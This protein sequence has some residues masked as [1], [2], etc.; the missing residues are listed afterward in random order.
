MK[1]FIRIVSIIGLIS[2]SQLAYPDSIT[3]TY[4]TGDTLTATTLNN[5]KSAVNDN[6]SRITALEATLAAHIANLSN[7]HAVTKDQVGLANLEDIRVNYTAITSPTVDDDVNSGYSVGSV[8]I[9]V[10]KKQ[11]YVLVDSSAGQAVWKRV[12]NT[13]DI[14]QEGPAGGVVFF[15]TG[16]GLHGLEAAPVDQSNAAEW[17][18]VIGVDIP[19]ADGTAI[20]TGAQNT[21][22]ILAA[23]P[24]PGIAARLADNYQLNG[25]TDWYLPS[26]D[27][28]NVMRLNIGLINTTT[29]NPG[30]FINDFYWSS[31]EQAGDGAWRQF[32]STGGQGVSGKLQSYSVR[33]IRAF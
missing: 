20:G 18:C 17:G 4:N 2:V 33:A 24:N 13:Y 16:G 6:D 23:C 25:F 5:I 30:N 9:D 11:A 26:K 32:F 15:V 28:L 8:W 21:A 1:Y 19:G 14:G 3:D 29:G 27:T 31:S 22:D 12:T 10:I 7:P